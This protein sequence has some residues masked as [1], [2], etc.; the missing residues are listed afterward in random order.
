MYSFFEQEIKKLH[1]IK[2]V[3]YNIDVSLFN[4]G[5]INNK[6][7]NSIVISSVNSKQSISYK[8]NN[9]PYQHNPEGILDIGTADVI[10][11]NLF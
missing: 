4:I 10:I 7:I 9:I 1:D 6:I 5:T 3:R 2:Y 8:N 11:L